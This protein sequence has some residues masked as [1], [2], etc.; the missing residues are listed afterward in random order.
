M[1]YNNLI[2]LS[3]ALLMSGTLSAMDEGKE[4]KPVKQACVSISLETSNPPN[5]VTKD[6]NHIVYRRWENR[7]ANGCC[8]IAREY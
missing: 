4:F 6:I 8:K 2:I 3:L 7:I 1:K 5:I